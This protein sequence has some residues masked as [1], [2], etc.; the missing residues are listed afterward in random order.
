[1]RNNFC[2]YCHFLASFTSLIFNHTQRI[3]QFE[4]M[5]RPGPQSRGPWSYEIRAS[6]ELIRPIEWCLGWTAVINWHRR[7][8]S[9][10]VLFTF[11]S[12][13]SCKSKNRVYQLSIGWFNWSH[14]CGRVILHG[15]KTQIWNYNCTLHWLYMPISPFSKSFLRLGLEHWRVPC[16]ITLKFLQKILKGSERYI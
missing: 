10:M 3:H 7:S 5:Q 13:Q 6:W 16:L 2:S 9:G 14:C 1:M 12:T 4:V 15:P 8:K 11:A